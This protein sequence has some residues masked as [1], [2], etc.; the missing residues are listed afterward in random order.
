MDLTAHI[1]AI[2]SSNST[3]LP[4]LH[5]MYDSYRQELYWLQVDT[6][7]EC[8]AGTFKNCARN[9]RIYGH[10]RKLKL[11]IAAGPLDLVAMDIFKPFPKTT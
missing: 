2:K 1:D 8:I 4:G 9:T 11:F 3:I 10:M 7:I 5:H 6:N